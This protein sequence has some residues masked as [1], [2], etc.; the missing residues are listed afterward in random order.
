MKRIVVVFDF[1]GT[2]TTKDT[3]LEFIKYACGKWYFYWGFLLFSPILILMKLHLFA[4]WK[5]KEMVFTYFFKGM[6]YERFRRL[7]LDFTGVVERIKRI[8][9]VEKL[10]QHVSEGH[11][12]YVI[13]AS[14]EDWVRPWCEKFNVK[15]VIGTKIEVDKNGKLTGKFLSKNCYGQEKV[16]R[17][18]KAEPYRNDY[19]LI[20]YGDSRGDKEILS[21]ADEGRYIS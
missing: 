1:D 18:M 12:V 13:S 9:V 19:T 10:Q 2:L 8:D 17:F 4:N 15:E 20:A 16:N 7:G 3:L 14:I 21:F 6:P 5:A 11:D